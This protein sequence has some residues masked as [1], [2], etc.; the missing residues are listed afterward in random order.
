VATRT[1]LQVW[2]ADAQR[3]AANWSRLFADLRRLGFADVIV[4]WSAYGALHYHASKS[5]AEVV[6]VLNKIIAAARKERV[7]LW[8]GLN[9]DPEFWSHVAGEPSQVDVYLKDRLQRARTQ[10][11]ELQALLQQADPQRSVVRGWY[12]SDEVDD[13]NWNDAQ[14]LQSLV[15]YLSSLRTLL[16]QARPTWQVAISG[17]SNGKV[18]AADLALFWRSLLDRTKIDMLL[19]QDGIGAEK[20]SLS[21]WSEYA[22]ALTRVFSAT[23]HSLRVVVELFSLREDDHSKTQAAPPERVMQQ[24]HLAAQVASTGNAVFSAPDHLLQPQRTSKNKLLKA[25]RRTRA[26]APVKESEK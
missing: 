14:R 24:L 17:F 12:I 13:V 23:P 15:D 11:V 10:I 9:Y 7:T 6:P 2:R 25:W 21:R 3:S 4:Q 5:A 22:N 20:L 19:F 26:C 1:F 18:P 16:R 8:M